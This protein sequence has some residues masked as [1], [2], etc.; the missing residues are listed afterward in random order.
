MFLRVSISS[1]IDL[2][3]FFFP[4]RAVQLESQH[5]AAVASNL[6]TPVS[7]SFFLFP[8]GHAGETHR[9]DMKTLNSLHQLKHGVLTKRN[10]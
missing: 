6:G 2:L 3:F 7:R 9:E 5:S 4:P 10:T 1:I 8:F